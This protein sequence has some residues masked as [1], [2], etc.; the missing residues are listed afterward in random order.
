MI[1]TQDRKSRRCQRRQSSTDNLMVS[2]YELGLSRLAKSARAAGG[3]VSLRRC[4]ISPLKALLPG[5]E[6]PPTWGR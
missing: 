1:I 6:A 5:G 2:G 4:G 3:V